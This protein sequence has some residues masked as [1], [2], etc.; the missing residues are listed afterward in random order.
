MV[1]T[2]D[3]GRVRPTFASGAPVLVWSDERHRWENGTVRAARGR[4]L[5]EV[6]TAAVE[7][8]I[9]PAKHVLRIAEGGAGALLYEAARRGSP[10]LVDALIKGGVSVFE[11]DTHA[12]THVPS[13]RARR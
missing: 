5:Y 9:C 6:K 11:A 13:D 4:G 1:S 3:P 8:A 12:N 7:A 10:R 2:V